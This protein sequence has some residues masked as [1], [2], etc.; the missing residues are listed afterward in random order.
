MITNLIYLAATICLCIGSMLEFDSNSL[1]NYFFVG[2]SSLFV[3]KSLMTL[4][5][6]VCEKNNKYQY[7]LINL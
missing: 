5:T 3:I 1:R 7:D 2:G 4:I 6:E